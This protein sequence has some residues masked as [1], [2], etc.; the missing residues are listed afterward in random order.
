[1]SEKKQRKAIELI[2]FFWMITED[3]YDKLRQIQGCENLQDLK[4]TVSDG[5][6]IKAIADNLGIP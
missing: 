3:K 1:M 6:H 4:A 5:N 2:K